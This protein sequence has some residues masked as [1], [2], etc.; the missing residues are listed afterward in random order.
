MS[1]EK[2]IRI[3][4]RTGRPEL[5]VAATGIRTERVRDSEGLKRDAVTVVTG[6][7]SELRR[8]KVAEAAHGFESLFSQ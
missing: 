1:T 6:W 7:I 5:H 8:K 2:R 4:K 3:I